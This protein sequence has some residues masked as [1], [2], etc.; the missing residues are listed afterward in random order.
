MEDLTPAE[1]E[2]SLKQALEEAETLFD[3]LSKPQQKRMRLFMDKLI[4]AFK[5]KDV[6]QVDNLYRRLGTRSDISPARIREKYVGPVP[7]SFG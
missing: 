1:L 2:V 6:A 3:E 7:M 4:K 5:E